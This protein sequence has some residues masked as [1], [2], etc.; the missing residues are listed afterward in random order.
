MR[1]NRGQMSAIEVTGAHQYF[2]LA[3]SQAEVGVSQ[4]DFEDAFVTSLLFKDALTLPDIFFFISAYI[5][6]DLLERKSSLFGQAV[7]QGLVT[8]WFREEAGSFTEIHDI[9]G[10]QGIIGRRHRAKTT[11]RVLDAICGADLRPKVT[12]TDLG[13]SYGNALA[14]TLQV[15]SLP[16]EAQVDL[17]AREIW[18]LTEEW[19]YAGLERARQLTSLQ[20]TGVRRGAIFTQLARDLH[21]ANKDEEIATATE[22]LRRFGSAGTL[23]KAALEH[24]LD[25]IN[26]IYRTSQALAFSSRPWLPS[27]DP[28]DTL[29]VASAL[30]GYGAQVVADTHEY[31]FD[32]EITIP[33]MDRLINSADPRAL[34]RIRDEDGERYRTRLAH[35]FESP[36]EANAEELRTALQAYSRALR[37]QVPS[38]PIRF[39]LSARRRRSPS[40]IRDL[41]VQTMTGTAGAAGWIYDAPFA[42]GVTLSV[43]GA[44]WL[45][46]LTST[47]RKSRTSVRRVIRI[48]SI[49]LPSGS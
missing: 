35:Y 9:I 48:P 26:T 32:E 36:S 41:L 43:A 17:D 33:S 30:P 49:V 20:G 46:R 25:G 15:P 28:I 45:R 24:F 13:I 44:L 34:I 37:K 5:E 21:L 8:P 2:G 14:T 22:V 16:I 3:D 23:E 6:F 7:K 1:H 4:S 31:A 27:A 19:R 39:Q 11:A 42:P 47:V 38:R 29:I 12:S 40:G 10:N 18:A